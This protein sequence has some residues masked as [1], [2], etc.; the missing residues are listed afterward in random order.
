MT[1]H[2]LDASGLICPLPVLKARKVLEGLPPGE[3]LRIRVTDAAAPKDFEL[4]CA[5]SGHIFQGVEDRGG[6]MDVQVKRRAP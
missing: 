3:V 6:H 4:Y 1:E 5:E 2:F